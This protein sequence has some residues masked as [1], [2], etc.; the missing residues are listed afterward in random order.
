MTD[1]CK[2]FEISPVD[3]LGQE[4]HVCCD[5]PSLKLVVF[6]VYRLKCLTTFPKGALQKSAILLKS[7]IL[8]V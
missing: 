6:G 7:K 4:P 3:Q 1:G 5:L 8:F 2:H